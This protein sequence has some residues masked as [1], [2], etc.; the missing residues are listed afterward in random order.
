MRQ[1][2]TAKFSSHADYDKWWSIASVI[3]FELENSANAAEVDQKLAT[4]NTIEIAMRDLMSAA[5]LQK[6]GNANA[7]NAMKAVKAPGAKADIAPQWLVDDVTTT[8][9]VDYQRA[10]RTASSSYGADGA[11]TYRGPG[12]RGGGRGEGAGKGDKAN[13]GDKGKKGK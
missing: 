9:K 5:H 4:S 3:D 11:L 10:Q 12:G 13:K 6:T 8:D 2:T 7:A 1:W